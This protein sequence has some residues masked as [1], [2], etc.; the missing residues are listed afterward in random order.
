MDEF[1]IYLGVLV[2]KYLQWA[3]DL[4][5]DLVVGY[6]FTAGW[7]D[8]RRKA[9]LHHEHSAQVV[10]IL[11]RGRN[12]DFDSHSGNN[13]V[14]VHEKY[15]SPRY[16]L[17]KKNVT[18]M[19]MD[20]DHVYFCESDPDVDVTDT[21]EFPFMFHGQYSHS[22]RLVVMQMESFHR[23]ADELGDPRVPVCLVNMTARCGS[24]LISQM[25]NRVPNVKS[26]SEPMALFQANRLF[27]SGVYNWDKTR[28]IIRS[29]IRLHCKV[30]PDSK[31][32]RIVIKMTPNTSPM[33]RTI[34]EFFP[35]IVLIFNS[36][37]PKPSMISVNK[38]IKNIEETNMYI[39]LRL[40]IFTMH[41]NAFP[42]PYKEEYFD[43]I[44]SF[45]KVVSG[46]YG[47]DDFMVFVWGA[48]FLTYTQNKDL[49]KHVV[50]YENLVARPEE[51]AKKLFGVLGISEE[52]IPGALEALKG[53]SQKGAWGKREAKAPEIT[54]EAWDRIDGKLAR[55]LPGIS[56][57]MSKD[58]FVNYFKK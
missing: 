51:E 5:L 25:M 54:A 14:Y 20:A 33:F 22:R 49:Y 58:D 28:R 16:V 9:W 10:R 40:Q 32:E 43:L 55:H 56:S 44:G 52:Y 3:L 17:E 8:E 41:S 12:I 30:E 7:R 1:V 45:W 35:D 13:F 26:M 24:T 19:T 46:G 6:K 31:V 29:S 39:R 4:V 38:A 50:L 57:K 47:L 37:H 23:M 53:D 34:H 36:R 18:L 27:R 21:K 42:F 11:A 2:L 15:V 48:T